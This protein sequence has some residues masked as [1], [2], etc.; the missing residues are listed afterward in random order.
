MGCS[1]YGSSAGAVGLQSV[2]GS[3]LDLVP[4][5]PMVLVEMRVLFSDY[6]VLEI[7]RELAE[8]NEFVTLANKASNKGTKIARPKRG[9]DLKCS[10]SKSHFRII[11]CAALQLM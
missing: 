1:I 8:R 11:V 3:D 9:L 4:I 7:D 2:F 5:E 6:S 10:A